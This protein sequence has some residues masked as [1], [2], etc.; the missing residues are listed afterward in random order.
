MRAIKFR[1]WDC[2]ENRFFVP[3][4][5]AY[6]GKLCELLIGMSGD[7][8]R[9]TMSGTEHESMFSCRYILEQYTGLH[10]KNG[11]EIYEGDIL[12]EDFPRGN[13]YQIFAVGGGFAMNIHPDDFNKKNIIFYGA[14]ADM[15]TADYITNSCKIIGNIHQNPELLNNK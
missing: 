4:Y 1:A 8:I 13:K 14:I 2:E 11:V 6:K 7:I 12:L 9:R 3:T 15:Q 10:D 5:E